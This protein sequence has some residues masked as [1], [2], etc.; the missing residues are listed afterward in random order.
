MNILVINCG[1]SSLKYQ[2][3]DSESEKVLAKGLC[4]RIGI[5]GSAI[6]H[7]PAGGAKVT[8]EADMPD[9]TVAVKLVI[10]KLTDKEV[11]VISSLEE[12]GA[13]GP[14]HRMCEKCGH[15]N[16]VPVSPPSLL[17]R[18]CR[19]HGTFYLLRVPSYPPFLPH[20]QKQSRTAQ[21]L[22]SDNHIAWNLS[23]FDNIHR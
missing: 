16:G 8:V 6:T 7:Q 2:L 13:V 12:I 21:L 23:P 17:Y 1:S 5:D 19:L 18:H 9:H 20:M 14:V 22:R 10:E 4:E 15:H 3:I 11:G